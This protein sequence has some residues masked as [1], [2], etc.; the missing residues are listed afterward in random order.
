VRTGVR[1]WQEA[2]GVRE[3]AG[4]IRRG[5]A[6]PA[7]DVALAD[8]AER[9][10]WEQF[11]TEYPFAWAF[12]YEEWMLVLNREGVLDGAWQREAHVLELARADQAEERGGRRGGRVRV[13]GHDGARR[14]VRHLLAH[15][16][17]VKIG[18]SAPSGP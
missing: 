12:G 9:S 16:G 3:A 6:T 15:D 18:T 17:P 2:Q 5:G 11:S 13:E 14:P 4:R 10:C 8:V 7:Q 1:S